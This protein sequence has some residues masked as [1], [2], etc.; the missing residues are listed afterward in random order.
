MLYIREKYITLKI[1]NFLKKQKK[2]ILGFFFRVYHKLFCELGRV[3]YHFLAV[4]PAP[5]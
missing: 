3:K 5:I 4:L 2:K 1:R